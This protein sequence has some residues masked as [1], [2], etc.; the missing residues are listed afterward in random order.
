MLGGARVLCTTL[1]SATTGMNEPVLPKPCSHEINRSE[2]FTDWIGVI[3][4]Q[5]SLNWYYTNLG[6]VDILSIIN[7]SIHVKK[8]KI[9]N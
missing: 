8:E 5:T 6:K 4:F 1:K 3:L 7:L 2:Q 9:L